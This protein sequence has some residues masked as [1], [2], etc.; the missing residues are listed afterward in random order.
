[1]NI[2]ENKLYQVYSF[3]DGKQG[4]LG[5]LVISP[6][7]I[8]ALFIDERELLES[9][10]YSGKFNLANDFLAYSKKYQNQLLKMVRNGIEKEEL[11]IL[12]QEK[13]NLIH[14]K[15]TSLNLADSLS[16]YVKFKFSEVADILIQ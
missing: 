16:S 12:I 7:C 10:N 2:L 13:G 1:M 15:G 11:A 9:I 8:I 6:N 4:E 3:S 14:E 5:E